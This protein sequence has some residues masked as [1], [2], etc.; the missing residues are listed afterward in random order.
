MLP[1]NDGAALSG[2]P[3]ARAS[4]AAALH[5]APGGWR[6]APL[7]SWPKGRRPFRES[8]RRH[9]DRWWPLQTSRRLPLV[10]LD[11]SY[12]AQS[13]SPSLPVTNSRSRCDYALR[14]NPFRGESIKVNLRWRGGDRVWGSGFLAR[15]TLG[16]NAVRRRSLTS[17][18]GAALFVDL[19]GFPFQIRTLALHAL[20]T[21]RRQFAQDG[22][23]WGPDYLGARRPGEESHSFT[24]AA[25]SAC[26]A[27]R[28]NR[29]RAMP[30]GV[31]R[32]SFRRR[33]ACSVIR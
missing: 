31:P 27:S 7:R 1:A 9:P 26:R 13:G 15:A 10:P 19:A 32:A 5:Q 6:R 29:S 11:I 17:R 30:G 24:C 21:G 23:Y 18:P 8:P 12:P 20:R 4:F 25:V 14:R 2:G 3:I 16:S 28:I 22:L 33:S